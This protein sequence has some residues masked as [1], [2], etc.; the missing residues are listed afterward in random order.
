MKITKKRFNEITTVALVEAMLKVTQQGK[1]IQQEIALSDTEADT[2]IIPDAPTEDPQKSAA[3][4]RAAHAA[5]EG[6]ATN[7][8]S[9]FE[10][11]ESVF[12][13]NFG[14]PGWGREGVG[15]AMFNAALATWSA[16]ASEEDQKHFTPTIAAIQKQLTGK[17]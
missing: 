9:K 2:A 6:R 5:A 8:A 13:N 16:Y 17:S 15:M 7:V 11:L 3:D 12:V 10:N 14:V 1:H 4:M